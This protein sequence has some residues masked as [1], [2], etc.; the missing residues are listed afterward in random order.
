MSADEAGS[1]SEV[2]LAS[3]SI[4]AA[5]VPLRRLR[6]DAL[7]PSSERMCSGV[8]GLR[9][10]GCLWSVTF[11]DGEQEGPKSLWRKALGSSQCQGLRLAAVFPYQT[12]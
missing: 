8:I 1:V 7:L 4:D 3:R 11:V 9:V 5:S 6:G 12:L 2:S 10:R